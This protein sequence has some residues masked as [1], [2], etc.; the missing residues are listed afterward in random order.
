VFLFCKN[1]VRHFGIAS[2]LLALSGVVVFAQETDEE[3]TADDN[4]TIEEIIVIAPKPG[5]RRRVDED[6]V[7]PAKAKLLKDFYQMQE[8]D[9]ELAWRDAAA[10][11][12]PDR[13]K[14][15]YDP[16]DDYNRRMEMD[17]T[18]L[19]SERNKPATLFK[20]SF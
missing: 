19:P 17:L 12:S 10:Q 11:E 20:V 6:Y 1:V 15:G 9:K 5:D 14:W 18:E 16:K 4:E 2:A 7:D 8:D 13:I 3:E